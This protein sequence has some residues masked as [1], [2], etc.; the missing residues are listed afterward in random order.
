MAYKMKGSPF[1]RNFP[2]DIKKPAP[3]KWINFVIQGISAIASAAKKDKEQ[4]K[5]ATDKALE[6]SK[7]KGDTGGKIGEGPKPTEV[8]DATKVEKFKAAEKPTA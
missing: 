5:A 8:A 7:A 1:Q 6:A 4:R 2:N 3:T